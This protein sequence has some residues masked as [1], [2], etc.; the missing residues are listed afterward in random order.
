MVLAFHIAVIVFGSAIGFLVVLGALYVAYGLAFGLA[1]AFQ[2]P[3]RG[4]G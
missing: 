3:R 2:K 1:L 4:E